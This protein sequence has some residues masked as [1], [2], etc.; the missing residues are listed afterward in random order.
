[1]ILYQ[2]TLTVRLRGS[3]CA[4][5]KLDLAE[6]LFQRAMRTGGASAPDIVTHTCMLSVYSQQGCWWR[7]LR[8][9]RTDILPHMAR[10]THIVCLCPRNCLP[11]TQKLFSSPH[12][13]LSVFRI[14]RYSVPAIQVCCYVH[15]RVICSLKA[16]LCTSAVH[17][18]AVQI[19]A[20]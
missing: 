15:A 9:Y 10:C 8:L 14:V 17:A 12:F 3:Y 7:A 13:Q 11:V 2:Y 18:C 4:V 20:V 19:C 16:H 1:M 6:E 5:G